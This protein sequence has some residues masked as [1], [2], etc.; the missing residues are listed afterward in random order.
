MFLSQLHVNVANEP[1]R[2]WLGYIYRL[3]QRLWM[4]FP[5]DE[6]KSDDPFFVGAWSGPPPADPKPNRTGSGFLYRVER[7]GMPRILVQSA[8]R[9]NWEYAFQNAPYLV[10]PEPQ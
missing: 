9:P 1:G 6:R 10:Q 3:H 4:A 2:K 7:D 8:Q 5:D